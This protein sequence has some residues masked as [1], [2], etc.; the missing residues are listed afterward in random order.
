M[1]SV[2]K[3]VCRRLSSQNK[4]PYFINHILGTLGLLGPALGLL[5]NE[6]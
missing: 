5:G 1:P 3:I 6:Q 4:R 2:S